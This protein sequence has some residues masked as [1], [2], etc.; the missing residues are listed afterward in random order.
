MRLLRNDPEVFGDPVPGTPSDP[1]VIVA[2]LHHIMKQVAGVPNLR[3][4]W[5]FDTRNR[6][7]R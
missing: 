7:N 6:V 5:F 3:P 1:G 2:S 4:P